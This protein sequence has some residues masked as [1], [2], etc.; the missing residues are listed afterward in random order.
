M[1]LAVEWGMLEKNPA[2]GFK[3]F[4]EDNK[5]WERI[6]AEAGLPHVRIHDLRHSYASFLVNSGRTLF[7]VQQ[8]LGH[9]QPQVTQRYSH[10]STKT[11]QDAANTA[12]VIID[13][14]SRREP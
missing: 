14:A 2:A 3:L 10:L 1:N 9:S 6:R 13:S 11:L 12:S 8:I 7:E 5:V 4:N